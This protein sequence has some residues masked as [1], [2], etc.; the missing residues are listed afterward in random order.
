[1]AFASSATAVEPQWVTVG[2]PG[3]LPDTNGRGAVP[4]EYRISRTEV[5][6]GQYAEFLNAKAAASDPFELYNHRMGN[7][8]PPVAGAWTHGGIQR[9]AGPGGGINFTYAARPGYENKPVAWVDWYD[10]VRFANWMQNGQG[11]GDTETGAY[12]LLGGTRI[13]SNDAT[14]TRNPGAGIFLPSR[15]EWYKAAYYDPAKPGAAGYWNYP[16]RGD[17]SP[18]SDQPPGTGAPVP[19]H[20]ANFFKN[21]NQPNGYDDGY[22]VTGTPTDPAP[23]PIPT[24]NFLTD[25]G[26]YTLSHSAFGTFDQGG[27]LFEWTET[28][29]PNQAGV[30]RFLY[31]GSFAQGEEFMHKGGAAFPDAPGADLSSRGFRLAAIPEPAGAP[32]LMVGVALLGRRRRR[33]R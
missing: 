2:S 24:T 32:L 15:D 21:D 23:T 6:F 14:I 12:T 25:V 1:M 33:A 3:N 18:F 10:T 16:T 28:L 11:N 13:P 31:G 7:E 19:S 20:T 26:A 9:S 5:T 29:F 17:T 8:A 22:A 30:A 27:N 4:T